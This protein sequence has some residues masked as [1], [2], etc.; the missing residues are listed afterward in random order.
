[1]VTSYVANSSSKISTA[2]KVSSIKYCN[3]FVEILYTTTL[4]CYAEITHFTTT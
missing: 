4:R 3:K 2:I 1:M